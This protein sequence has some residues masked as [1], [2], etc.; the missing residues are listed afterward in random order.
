MAIK[1][2]VRFVRMHLIE[3]VIATLVGTW[4]S[5]SWLVYRFEHQ[6]QGAN[7]TTF[8]DGLWWGI[9]TFLTVGYG[10]RYP[11]TLEGRLVGAFLMLAGVMAIGIVT[12]KISSYFMEKMLRQGRGIVETNRLNDHF[13]ICG[14]REDMEKLLLHILDFNPGLSSENL[15]LIAHLNQS[16]IDGLR[17]DARLKKIQIITGDYFQESCL[18]RAAPE[19]ARKILVL[20]DKSPGANGQTPSMTE[21]DART[22]MTAMTLS[23]IARGTLVAAEILD[24]KMDQYLKL[25]SVS[26]IIYSGEYSRLLLGSA[27][28][29]TGV[30]NILFDLLDPKTSAFINTKP[31]TDF[32]PQLTYAAFKKEF[33]IKHQGCVVIGILE[34]TGNQH[35]IK[36]FALRQ[37]QKTPDM[38][39]LV[40]NLKAVKEIRCNY[41]V[42]NPSGHYQILEGSMAIVIENRFSG[43]GDHASIAA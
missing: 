22:I 35:R 3:F 27:S 19:R 32:G 40:A 2:L 13:V 4:V 42:L 5:C 17:E 9:V 25:A 12:A 7:V 43:E 37:A 30:T 20:A 6:A 34:N 11:I 23:N 29:G 41:P 16:T 15:V 21:I 31:I 10:D 28:G 1:S 14:W 26:E 18:K 38:K 24:P 33:E 39:K 8:A 36:E